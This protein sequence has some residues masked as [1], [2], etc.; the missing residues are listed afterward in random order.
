MKRKGF[1]LLEALIALLLIAA[2]A[3]AVFPVAGNIGRAILSGRLF[4]DMG[5]TA[6]FAMDF[7]TEKIRNDLTPSEKPVIQGNRFDYHDWNEYNQQ[8]RYT[9]YLEDEKLKVELYNGVRQPVTGGE[10]GDESI[11]FQAGSP[12][13]YQEGGGPLHIHFILHHRK[14][15]E[16]EYET[17]ILSYADFYRKGKV[18]E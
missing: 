15:K 2:A 1:L 17:S 13:F 7:M 10:R 8:S 3:S 6:L 12:L 18:Y 16:R 5:E 9:L 11:A 4:G 14:E